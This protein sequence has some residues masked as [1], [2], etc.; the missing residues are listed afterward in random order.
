MVVI[1]SN[2]FHTKRNNDADHDIALII[3]VAP[4]TNMV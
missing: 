4:L 1:I 3:A 2:I